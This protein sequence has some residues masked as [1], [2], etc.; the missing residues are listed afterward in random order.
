M[1]SNAARSSEWLKWKKEIKDTN[2]HRSTCDN[3]GIEL[4]PS[5]TLEIRG[6]CLCK[7]CRGVEEEINDLQST[8]FNLRR[9]LDVARK[10]YAIDRTKCRGRAIARLLSSI[11]VIDEGIDVLLADYRNIS[12]AKK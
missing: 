5:S 12:K 8:W 4:S 2:V 6:Y 9:Q 3:C 7:T 10:A 1:N 11:R